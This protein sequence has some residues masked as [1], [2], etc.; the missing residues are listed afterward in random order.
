VRRLL[1]VLL[2]VCVA[3]AVTWP[4]ALEPTTALVGYPNVD[5]TDTIMLRGL[6][7]EMLLSGSWPHSSGIY[8]PE[9]FAVGELVPNLVDHV[10]GA[11]TAL[12]LPFPLSD[13]LWWL[14]V[15]VGNG[16]AGHHL[17]RVLSGSW[18]GGV[19]LGVVW[20]CAESTLREANLHH[21]PQALLWFPPLYVAALVERRPVKAA[22]A[23]AAAALTYWYAAVF[24]TIGSLPFLLARLPTLSRA[25]AL[26]AVLVAAPL[27]WTVSAYEGFPDPQANQAAMLP[28]QETVPAEERMEVAHGGDLSLFADYRPIDRS[29]AQPWV[30]LA[31]AIFAA[32]RKEARPFL[33]MAALGYVFALGPYL[34][35][36]E[37]TLEV[38]LPFHALGELHPALDRLT[39][40]ERFGLLLTLGLAAAAT[41]ALPRH[42]IAVG[43]L[44]VLLLGEATARSD[45]LPLTTQDLTALEGW[46]VLALAPGRVLELPLSRG[47]D[48]SLVGLHRRYHR[49]DLLNPVLL[50]PGRRAPLAWRNT[51]ARNAFTS[52]LLDHE[53]GQEV[54]FTA[55]HA[56]ALTGL[57]VGALALDVRPGQGVTEGRARLYRSALEPLGWEVQDHCGLMVWWRDAPDVPSPEGCRAWRKAER[58]A[59]RAPRPELDTLIRVTWPRAPGTRP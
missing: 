51:L 42:P 48:A 40:P 6:V 21:A 37:A 53:A 39:W 26:T 13:N 11:L 32:R 50:P 46:R 2:Y 49:R 57:G 7:P 9:G 29:N 15:L 54:V 38:A 56:A 41:A 25:A 28:G 59:L 47:A 1:P 24:L 35:W 52:R 30:L 10:L 4:V 8:A 44:L 3:V 55:E 17:G 27:A 43:G 31:L 36:G 12:T 45:N 19:F 23:M 33:A 16:L 22:L 18:T 58:E 14:V 34:K 5:A 20:A